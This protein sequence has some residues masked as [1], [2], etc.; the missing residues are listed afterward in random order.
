M[1]SKIASPRG[2]Q[3]SRADLRGSGG[4]ERQSVARESQSR[5]SVIRALAAAIAVLPFA[6]LGALIV[7]YLT[8]WGIE[9]GT[10]LPRGTG[11][12]LGIFASVAVSL[13]AILIG[14]RRRR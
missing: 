3:P 7:V 11:L 9:M 12:L 8:W 4:V 5:K 13:G 10:R 14:S 1:R 2:P 6:V